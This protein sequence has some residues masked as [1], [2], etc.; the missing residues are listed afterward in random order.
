MVSLQT[1]QYSCS[2]LKAA[3]E[4]RQWN[5]QLGRDLV[6]L[7]A[8]ILQRETILLGN[9]MQVPVGPDADWTKAFRNNSM[10]TKGHL[11]KWVCICPRQFMRD[12]ETFVGN[13]RRVS[14]GMKMQMDQPQWCVLVRM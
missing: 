2:V 11:T 8:R 5:V 7:P 14:S 1:V 12:A 13:L 3:H 4:L 10:Y 6:K 9:E